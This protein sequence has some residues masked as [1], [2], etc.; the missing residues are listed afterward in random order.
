MNSLAEF[1]LGFTYEVIIVDNFSEDGSGLKLKNDFPE[2][3]F[4]LNND[5]LGFAKANNQALKIA[6]GNYI[7]FLNNDVIFRENVIESLLKYLDKKNDKLLI[8]PRLLNLDGTIQHSIYSFQTLWLSFTTYFF[9][10]KLFPKSKYF[11]RYYLMNKGVK[12]IINVETV[13]GAFMLSKK[14][15]ILELKGFDEDYFFY[16]EDN[17]LCKRFRNAGGKIIY[18]PKVEVTHLKGAT[19][20]SNWFHVKYHTISVVNL[21]RKHYSFPKRILAR[22]LFFIGIILRSILLIASY[23]YTLNRKH[24]EDFKLKIKALPIIIKG[25]A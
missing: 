4:I 6:N 15:D 10:Y 9:F 23:S 5:N 14:D 8:A 7:L 18:Y 19:K 2:Y 1:S 24:L 3:Q 16:G 22:I 12:E 13:T 20:K 11:N 25:K 17:D 21:F